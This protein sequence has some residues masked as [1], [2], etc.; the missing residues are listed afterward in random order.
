MALIKIDPKLVTAYIDRG[1]VYQEQLGNK[2][3]ACSDWKLACEL[4]ECYNYSI[5]GI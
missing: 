2:H 1:L 3:M 4:G 5:A